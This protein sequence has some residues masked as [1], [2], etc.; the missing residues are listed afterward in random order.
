MPRQSYRRRL[1]IETF[2]PAGHKPRA[3]WTEVDHLFEE[4]QVLLVQLYE[5]K[6]HPHC[7]IRLEKLFIRLHTLRKELFEKGC[8]YLTPWEG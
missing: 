5:L 2:P 8:T 4:H 3:D 6:Q 7:Q 1:A